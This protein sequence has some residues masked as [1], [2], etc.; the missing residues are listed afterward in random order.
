MTRWEI[1]LSKFYRWDIFLQK[2]ILK[3]LQGVKA[4]FIM[5][6]S[7]RPEWS[8][9]ETRERVRWSHLAVTTVVPSTN[10]YISFEQRL[11]FSFSHH[12][13][14][15]SCFVNLYCLTYLWTTVSA[16]MCFCTVLLLHVLLR[17][18]SFFF[19]EQMNGDGNIS[20]CHRGDLAVI[21][22]PAFFI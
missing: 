5:A 10:F 16:L 18:V 3:S 8:R 7:P 22:A 12:C 13:T 20:S 4:D 19:Y 1:S 6:R 14:T 21:W 2:Y 9:M 15:F 17:R 11:V